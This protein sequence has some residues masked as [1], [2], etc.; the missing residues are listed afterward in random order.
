MRKFDKFRYIIALLH[1][2]FEVEKQNI[3]QALWNIDTYIEAI[4][5]EFICQYLLE[6]LINN[7]CAYYGEHDENHRQIV[8][9]IN[10]LIVEMI[11]Y[12]IEINERHGNKLNL[13][14][15][16][17]LQKKLNNPVTKKYLTTDDL[18]VLAKAEYEVQHAQ[19]EYPIDWLDL[20]DEHYARLTSVAKTELKEKM[21][22]FAPMVANL[23]QELE[24][25]QEDAYE[26]EQDFIDA[27][28]RIVD[29]IKDKVVQEFSDFVTED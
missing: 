21:T 6:G 22:S 19:E 16:N 12:G 3:A 10:T 27:K 28:Q 5:N 23:F 18:Y 13:T 8:E 25:V 15:F 4:G 29:M 26:E 9:D 14:R 17:A 2:L 7:V 11:R 20:L 24:T 1:H